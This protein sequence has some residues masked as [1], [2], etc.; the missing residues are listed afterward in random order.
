MG[1]GEGEGGADVDWDGGVVGCQY[2]VEDEEGEE[3]DDYTGSGE[4]EVH[5]A[6]C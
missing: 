6:V 4:E 2:Y 5:R 1:G 3:G